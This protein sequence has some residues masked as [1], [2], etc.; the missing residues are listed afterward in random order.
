MVTPLY[1][2][3][4]SSMKSSFEFPEDSKCNQTNYKLLISAHIHI[5]YE[6]TIR[7]DIYDNE[8]TYNMELSYMRSFQLFTINL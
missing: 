7:P 4:D 2:E 1:A 6:F 5:S 3:Y 8:F